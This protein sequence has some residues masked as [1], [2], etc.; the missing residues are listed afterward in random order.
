MSAIIDEIEQRKLGNVAYFYFSYSSKD[1]QDL[2]QDL[3]HFK[4]S[5]LV[6][7]VCRQI[8]KDPNLFNHYYVPTAFQRLYHAYHPSRNPRDEDI[9]A[10]ILALLNEVK[11]TYIVID[12][13]DEFSSPAD[14]VL[15][16][17]RL[18]LRALTSVHILFTSRREEDIELAV[19]DVSVVKRIVTLDVLKVNEDIRTHLQEC[20]S[21]PPYVRWKDELKG[22]VVN[23]LSDHAGG[24]FRWADLQIQELGK[25][26]REKD[27]DKA[28][29]KLPKTLE[30]TYERILRQI[31]EDYAEEAHAI[32]QWLAYSC[33]P[34]S[35][36]QVAEIAAFDTSPGQSSDSEDYNVSFTP[37]NRFDSV[38]W[39]RRI[40]SGLVIVTGVDDRPSFLPNDSQVLTEEQ[41]ETDATDSINL[42]LS[43][44]DEY[45]T[46]P[47]KRS[48]I[49]S[50]G[51][52]METKFTGLP[53]SSETD[54]V[55]R[56]IPEGTVLFAHFSVKEYLEST[57]V[58]PSHFKLVETQGH[59]YIFKSSL[60]YLRHYD[61][62]C[63]TELDSGIQPLLI[64][65][66]LNWAYHANACLKNAAQTEIGAL[67]SKLA[68]VCGNAFLLSASVISFK[69]PW[70]LSD[71]APE[72]FEISQNLVSVLEQLLAGSR[73]KDYFSTESLPGIHLLNDPARD[74]WTASWAG[75]EEH[76]K[77]LL[78]GGY[79]VNMVFYKSLGKHMRRGWTPLHS[80][81][82]GGHSDVIKLLI[83]NGANVDAEFLVS[84]TTVESWPLVSL[85]QNFGH[86]E[87][88]QLFSDRQVVQT[89][90]YQHHGITPLAVATAAGNH[91]AVLQL[92]DSGAD[93]TISSE[94]SLQLTSTETDMNSLAWLSDLS[95]LS[96]HK[97][98][99]PPNRSDESSEDETSGDLE[100]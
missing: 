42:S 90:Q 25:K 63:F 10:T 11:E 51:S 16:L 48:S 58:H 53:V 43:P 83:V 95:L 92:L 2:W 79:N 19:G 4:Y 74:V 54:Q 34:L 12:A 97:P 5:I 75:H 41:Q 60:A 26:A 36:E 49:S 65:A 22:K 33:Q 77:V 44:S 76:V 9:D 100:W 52:E 7:L 8:R 21:R 93:A 29:K 87:L 40:L 18:C 81:A 71:Q 59:G 72:D 66:W 89:R 3:R 6:Q 20:M 82:E 57:N 84:D 15:F 94:L 68:N 45:D 62:K 96:Q 50:Y 17:D 13:L 67:I 35:L 32:L 99:M 64:Y 85:A 30:E 14:V 98:S 39:V 56:S 24:V 28:L 80:A 70:Y 31:D 55:L 69:L 73:Y 61:T 88:A 37:E 23:H 1:R 38:S 86:M 78:D 91:E 27:V 46:N 47:V